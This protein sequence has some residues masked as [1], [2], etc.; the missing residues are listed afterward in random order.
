MFLRQI[1]TKLR[2]VGVQSVQNYL[3]RHVSGT[4]GKFESELLEKW[5]QKLEDEKV[6]EIETSLEHILDH[7]LEKEKVRQRT[8]H[9]SNAHCEFSINCVH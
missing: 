4:L 8:S 3:T 5:K 9:S 6:P 1:N 7:I 2:A